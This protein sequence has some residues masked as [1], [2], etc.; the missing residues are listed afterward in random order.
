MLILAAMGAGAWQLAAI[1]GGMKFLGRGNMAE[2]ALTV[3]IV[4]LCAV[5]IY[6]RKEVPGTFLPF[7]YRYDRLYKN[8]LIDGHEWKQHRFDFISAPQT[9]K[10]A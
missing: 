1:L 10:I 5:V 3:A 6:T 2:L 4:A 9:H 8:G 7:F